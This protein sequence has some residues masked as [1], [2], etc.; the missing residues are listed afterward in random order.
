[1]LTRC[2]LAA[3]VGLALLAGI[4]ALTPP[5]GADEAGGQPGAGSTIVLNTYGTWRF[6]CTLAPV[7][8]ASGE[9]VKLQ[10][11][12][13]N[14]KTAGPARE[15]MGADFDDRFWDRGP[16]SLAPKSGLMSRLCL[17]GKF[18]V[19]DPAAVKGLRLSV[20]Y[21]G[22]LVVYVNGR[23]AHREHVEPDAA[24]AEGP[25]GAERN[26]TDLA[27]PSD[28]L[29][30]GMNVV[31]L[32]VVRAP[33]AERA[34]D[35]VYETSAC[36]IVRVRLTSAG[37]AGLV[38]NA[39][40]PQGFQVW[41]ADSMAEDV[42]VD[43]GDQAE[44]LQ[45]VVIVGTRN[46]SFS[47]KVVVG[48]SEAIRGLQATPA[49]LEGP[50]GAAIPAANVRIR[51]GILWGDHNLVN[52]GNRRWPEPYPT[53][54]ANRL[55]ALAEEPLEQFDVLVPQRDPYASAIPE[56]SEE[57]PLV[58]GAVAP[59]WITVKVPASVPAGTYTGSVRIEAGGEEPVQVPVELRVADWALPDTQDYRT[60]VDLIQCPDTLALE[61]GVPLWSDEH[62]DLIAQSFR[63]IG[64]T[65][66]RTVYVPL[67]AHTNLGNE[68]SM[69]RW[70]KDGDGYK[71]D[72]SVLDRYLDVA[73]ENMGRPKLVILVVWDVYMV[74]PSDTGGEARSRQR[75]IAQYVEKT[76]GS[77]GHGPMVTLLDPA[78][79]ETSVHTLPPHFDAEVSRPLW[80]PLFDQLGARMA[81][82]GLKDAMMLGLQCDA[83]A[84]KE[85]HQFFR[86]IAGPLPWVLQSH[87]GFGAN[88]RRMRE[89]R[90][91]LMHGI[92][93]IG[94]QARV[95]AVT[96]SD[97]NAD[98]GRSYEGGLKSHMG[99]TRPDL[100]AQFDRFSHEV[101]PNVRW[102][103]LAEAA[104]T[105]S[106]R[107]IG[108]LGAD[109]WKVI[110]DKRGR[111]VGRSHERYPESTWRN[112]FVPDALLAP[113][114]KGPAASDQLEA[115]REGVQECEARI[116]IEGALNDEALREQ[117]GTDLARRCEDYLHNRHMMMW[118]SL[119][120]LQLL[121][122]H[123]GASWGPHYMAR[124]WRGMANNGGSH[125]FLGSDW[126]LRTMQLYELAGEVA[127]KL[128]AE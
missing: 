94:Y 24:L 47:G 78:T 118:L 102:R 87:E 9:E 90:K 121:Y 97:D 46:G 61:Y 103:H 126:R 79:G 80:Q 124:C 71:H 120:D 62:F 106:Q 2:R 76:A 66:S 72:F 17:R 110:R 15:W 67:I 41:N 108:R 11:A 22:G 59:I 52:A 57:V 18:T 115:F 36:E 14:Y 29:R 10:W 111:R 109:Y 5:A 65:G 8:L 38:P 48:S 99:W 39:V 70:I 45:P 25:G 92:S 16:A 113:G 96:F 50:G 64:E 91:E 123:P 128:E 88:F 33:Y 114:P 112:L 54:G 23:E 86:D 127:R 77:I 55:G 69:V 56:D 84:S 117:I 13:L 104:I 75:Q 7:V 60:W 42:N 27:I 43:F 73:T 119:S 116:V 68:E 20:T 51:Y 53:R 89:P 4:G 3:L 107:G 81:K 83:W 95:W 93:E 49:G 30:E 6:H 1:M 21:R 98:R 44:P 35:D 40:R 100:V 125:W 74:P 105:G 101:H 37:P 31:G 12:W 34:E 122:D 82:R 85:E 58:N 19:T 63:L 26:L 32:E 28:L